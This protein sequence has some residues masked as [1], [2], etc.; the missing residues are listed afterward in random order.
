[1]S[2]FV[3]DWVGSS[4]CKGQRGKRSVYW[5]NGVCKMGSGKDKGVG[6]TGLECSDGCE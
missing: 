5:K 3:G 1:M 4:S 2:L 6:G